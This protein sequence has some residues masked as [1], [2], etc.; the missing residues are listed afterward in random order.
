MAYGRTRRGWRNQIIG[1][2]VGVRGLM[3]TVWHVSLAIVPVAERPQSKAQVLDD[4][5]ALP[6]HSF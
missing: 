4:S 6:H 3:R 5:T 1:T 2:W